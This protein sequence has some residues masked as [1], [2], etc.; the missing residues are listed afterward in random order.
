[1]QFLCNCLSA[2]EGYKDTPVYKVG[3]QREFWAWNLKVM[4][5]ED[6]RLPA[7]CRGVGENV[8]IFVSDDVWM[9]AVFQ[10]DIEKIIDVFDHSTPE[11]SIDSEKGI[12]EILTE[13]FGCPPDV[14]NDHRIY[15]LI[16]QLGEYHGHDFDGYFRF[17]DEF[18]GEHS[19]HAEILYLD[20]D[21]PSDDYSLGIIAHEFQHLIHWQYDRDEAGWLGESLSEIAMILCGYYTDK[22]HVIK[23][24]NNTD[25]PLVS[26]GHQMVDYGACLLWGTYI[27]ERMGIEFLGNLI[28]EK[29]NGI[30]GFQNVLN[31]M[32]I[33]D[34]FSG[35]FGEWLVTNYLSN[36]LVGDGRFRY[37]SI[38]LPVTPTVKHFFSLPV[39]GAGEI[40][41]YA[42]DYLKFSI[43]RVNNKTLRINF[44]SDCPEDFLIRIIRV[45]NDNLLDASVE[46]VVLREPAEAFDV[47]DVGADCREVVLV[48]SVLKTTEG[49]VPYSFSVSLVPYLETTRNQ[50]QIPMR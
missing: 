5:P 42:A 32:N 38:S 2:Q 16:S 4:P 14:D 48:V 13:T 20:C 3:D 1:M 27:Y 10:K 29:E 31:N 6:T 21:N 26:R 11:T 41:G 22:K 15:F 7:T 25:S 19:N 35:I 43:G 8:Y 23:Y 45:D 36:S 30:K 28:R 47:S 33:E 12:Y 50:Y 37:R 34:D 49:P 39:H 40:N 46:D 44:M 18:E 24:L 9:S 17:F